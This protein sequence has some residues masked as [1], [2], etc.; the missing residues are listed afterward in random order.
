MN[1]E[2]EVREES[3]QVPFSPENIINLETQS[4]NSNSER[5]DKKVVI[6]DKNGNGYASSSIMMGYNK[7]GY[8]LGDGNFVNADEL[9]TAI[10][11]AVSRYESG[12]VIVNKRTEK[13]LNVNEL[14][15][16]LKEAKGSLILGSASAAIKNQ[17]SATLKI[18]STDGREANKGV[19]FL[20]NHGLKLK[21]GEYVSLDEFLIALNDYVA[22]QRI[23]KPESPISKPVS[24][25]NPVLED[26]ISKS[27]PQTNDFVSDEPKIV[28]VTRKYKNKS[29]IWLAIL[30]CMAV[31]ISGFS[32]K[33]NIQTIKVPVD[34]VSSIQYESEQEILYF[35]I[36]GI[37]YSYEPSSSTLKRVTEN[38][39]LGD[40]LNV[41]DGKTFNTNG[42][43]TGV[44]KTMGQEFTR[45]GKYSGNYRI[46]GFA[47]VKD[48]KVLSYVEDFDGLN[49]TTKLKNIIDQT[50]EENNL[51]FDDLQIKVHLGANGDHSRLGW[52]DISEL[53][54]ADTIT[55]DMILEVANRVSIDKGTVENFTGD[56]ITLSNGVTLKIT[57]E[58][59]NLLSKGSTIIGSDGKEY[60]INNLFLKNETKTVEAK[61][62]N[63]RYETKEV[64][65]GKSLDWN[66]TDCNLALGIVPLLSAAAFAVANKKKNENEQKNPSFFEFEN[67][68]EYLKFKKEFEDAKLKYESS[69]KFNQVL[70]SIFF[71]KRV[72]LMQK[73][74]NEQS[75]ELYR[76]IMNHAGRDFVFGDNDRI[77]FKDGRVFV[78]YFD[79][80]YA[81]ITDIVM[82]DIYSIGQ[83]NEI[84]SEGR[85]R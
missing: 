49:D 29:S 53:I 81:D 4:I 58:D 43:E 85:L 11:D 19:L 65:T 73:L 72:D 59:G 38:L 54:N 39:T 6:Y 60:I 80:H 55:D 14:I 9:I 35:E 16:M 25:S 52:I 75:S 70:K 78:N 56:Y 36:D 32:K 79:G 61:F 3:F 77:S 1:N 40:E 28:R 37:I 69:S 48:G 34:V 2:E 30:G 44:S 66:I 27:K 33:D 23:S 5:Q 63:V 13:T 42:L 47:L 20:G 24:D 7:K 71:R 64:V 26:D 84:I 10:N 74:S 8:V 83:N 21:T 12:T 15:E 17:D 41:E 18:K 68:D 50:L 82:P 31:L 46:T 62:T 22:V 51:Q 45:E 67:N 57:D 76:V